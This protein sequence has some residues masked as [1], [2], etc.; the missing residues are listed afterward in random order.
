MRYLNL[1]AAP[2]GSSLGSGDKIK[3]LNL[4]K[5]IGFNNFKGGKL[6]HLSIEGFV[7]G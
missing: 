1:D 7:K 3:I 5:A 2:N 4:G 6:T